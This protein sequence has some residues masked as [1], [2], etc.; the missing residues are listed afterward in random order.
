[1]INVVIYG[2]PVTHRKETLKNEDWLSVTRCRIWFVDRDH[3]LA[4]E[5]IVL[6]EWT[7][8]GRQVEGPVDCM[9]CLVVEAQL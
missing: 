3:P 6:A 2:D 8:K 5:G 9:A 4:A 7:P 1:M